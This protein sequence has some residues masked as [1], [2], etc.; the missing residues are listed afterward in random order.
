MFELGHWGECSCRFHH[1][2]AQSRDSKKGKEDPEDK[3]E[4]GRK[5]ED[6]Q[7]TE[8]KENEVFRW[9]QGRDETQVTDDD[10]DK[11]F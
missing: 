3:T 9:T 11:A 6:L 5:D 4:G 7:V 10:R 1:W 8:D 2:P